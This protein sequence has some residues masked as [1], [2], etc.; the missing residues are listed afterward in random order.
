[1]K[2][3]IENKNGL[4][5]TAV[6]HRDREY[7]YA[8]L[9]DNVVR[10][11]EA[12]HAQ[13]PQGAVVAVISDYSFEA[14]CC[15]LALYQNNN[16]I[17]NIVPD[18]NTDGSAALQTVPADYVIRFDAHDRPA[19][20][21]AGRNTPADNDVLN[22]LRSRK[23]A[24]LLLLSSGSTGQPKMM[25]HDLD[26]LVDTFRG[27]RE[28]RLRFVLFLM[29]DHIGGINTLL[30]CLAATATFVIPERREPAC[31]AALIERHAVNVLP[32]TPTFLKLMVI[33]D[34]IGRYDLSSLHVITFGAERMPEEFLGRLKKLFPHTK[35]IQT[36]GTSETGIAATQSSAGA[37]TMMKLSDPN[38]EYAIINGELCL[39]SKTRI[40]GYLD[41]NRNSRLN[42]DEWF[43]TGDMAA[44]CGNGFFRIVG[45][46]NSLI[47]VGG[48]KVLPAEV[49]GVLYQLN[50]VVDC[51]VYAETNALMGQ[52]VAADVLWDCPKTAAEVKR[53]IKNHCRGKLDAYKIPVRIRLLSELKY[54]DRFKKI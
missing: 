2:W 35:F 48:E 38:T 32:T 29:F 16:I 18:N 7:T 22:D 51:K 12:L 28:K 14:V 1:M 37:G 39:K 34:V 54:S 15:F 52:I 20:E 9:Y 26:V 25:V 50:H 33:S 30:N 6:I 41:S 19:I 42:A 11:Y 8:D 10:R 43:H 45:R 46:K 40:V 49:E 21:P 23:H 53:E 24:G 36:F 3:I 27:R 5:K 13:I 31:I 44:D 47:N 4:Q 17:V